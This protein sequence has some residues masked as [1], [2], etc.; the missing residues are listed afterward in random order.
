MCGLV[1]AA[2]TLNKKEED[3]FRHLLI[4]DSLRGMDSTGAAFVNI[5][6]DVHLAKT[7]GD[8]FQLLETVAFEAGMRQANSCLIGHNRSA[9]IGKVVRKNAH[10]FLTKNIV[11][12]H[13]GTLTNKGAIPDAYQYDT[14]S[15]AIFNSIDIRGAKETLAP[16]Q[17]A[18]ALTWYDTRTNA[19]HLLRNKER[20]LFVAETK[21]NKCVFWASEAWMLH[22]ILQRQ[23]V[24]Y[25][26]IWLLPEDKEYTYNIP[27]RSADFGFPIVSEVKQNPVP[28]SNF[29][30]GGC[31]GHSTTTT[32]SSSNITHI[33]KKLSQGALKGQRLLL[34]PR[35]SGGRNGA[36]YV[37]LISEQY[38]GENFRMFCSTL[39]ECQTRIKDGQQYFTIGSFKNG[40]DRYYKVN[41][42]AEKVVKVDHHGF[43]ITAAEFYQRYTGCAFCSANLEY[44]TNFKILGKEACLCVDCAED[45]EIQN[46]LPTAP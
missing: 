31:M 23:S 19:V 21:D 41:T 33:N 42:K 3:A 11:G 29:V 17:G 45:P 16:V 43:P 28:V 25:K 38:K 30:K 12:A 5:L 37:N 22:A 32:N 10:P 6:K 7:V 1:G 2:G 18:Y 13:N 36:Y 14:D 46:Y 20:P 34:N 39:E 27:A 40:V 26:D 24:D 15:E 44:L 8:P 4:L 35:W 9:T